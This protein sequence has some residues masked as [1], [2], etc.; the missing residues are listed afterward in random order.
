MTPNN[1]LRQYFR[2]PAIYIRLP[3]QGK[4][5]APGTLNMPANAELPVLPMTAIDEITYRT[6]D[7]LYNGQATV[8]VIQSCIPSIVDAWAMPAMDIDTVLTSI[9]IASYGHTMEF[10]T[11]CP[12]CGHECEHGLDLRSVIDNMRAPDYDTTI[13]SGDIELFFQ[14]MTYR[15]LNENNKTQL[16]QQKILKMLPDE[17]VGEDVKMQAL[18]VALKQITES[19]IKALSQSIAAIKTPT[20]FVNEPEFIEDLLSNCDRVL[21]NKIRDHI[22]DIKAK[23][24]LQPLK[25]TCPECN[26]GYDQSVTLDMSSFFAPAS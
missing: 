25:L 26:H 14:P 6:P 3:S 2:Q 7:A 16:E 4:F 8:N 20:A 21:F 18:S 13:Q 17:G 24:E 1:P 10:G 19:T 22:I 9:R 23:A 11:R 5:Y 15:N 12:A